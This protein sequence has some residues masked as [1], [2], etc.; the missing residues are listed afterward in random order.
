M[1]DLHLANGKPNVAIRYIF[2]VDEETGGGLV[3]TKPLR[4]FDT[5]LEDKRKKI[6]LEDDKKETTIGFGLAAPG[7]VSSDRAWKGVNK[8][9][10]DRPW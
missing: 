1:R 5:W 9:P 7:N 3:F 2:A 6:W 4:R 8:C 10:Q